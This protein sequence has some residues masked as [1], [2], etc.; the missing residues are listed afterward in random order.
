MITVAGHR[1]LVRPFGSEELIETWCPET[2]RLKVKTGAVLS[3]V[4]NG[5]EDPDEVFKTS[6]SEFSDSPDFP[7]QV[8]QEITEEV[9]EECEEWTE[10]YED[11]VED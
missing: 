3:R 4:I 11:L 8:L 1:G 6:Y 10:D 9:E 2:K 7:D 5:M